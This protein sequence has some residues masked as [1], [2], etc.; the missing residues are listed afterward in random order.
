MKIVIGVLVVVLGVCVYATVY[1]HP[2]PAQEATAL[3]RKV[4]GQTLI[5]ASAP[6]VRVT[7][8]AKFQY[9]GGQRFILYS[10]ANA[11]QH[12]FV[13]ADAQKKVKRLYW[14]QFE[15][16]LPSNTHTYDYSDEPFKFQ[17]GGLEWLSVVGGG[18]M[19]KA[20]KKPDSDGARFRAFLRAK[21]YQ[22]PDDEVQ[23]R[24]VNLDA[25]RRNE[26]MIIYMEDVSLWGT[27]TDNIDDKSEKW[28]QMQQQLIEHAKAGL[29]I[30]R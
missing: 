26:L 8:D 15:G 20:E 27:T 10:V 9:A 30:E 3:E 1:L 29:K 25:A 28:K 4:D 24:M 22:L 18:R 16:Y 5:S 7:V 12:F 13:E 21:G 2:A 6:K 11:E 23:V 19:P 14:F 17:H